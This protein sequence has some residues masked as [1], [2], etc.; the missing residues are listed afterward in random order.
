MNQRVL[1]AIAALVVVPMAS[2]AEPEGR[3]LE[4]YLKAIGQ[5][6]RLDENLLADIRGGTDWHSNDIY[7]TGQVGQNEASQLT[8]GSNFVNGGA[9]VNASGFPTVVQNSGNNVLIQNAT[10]INLQLQ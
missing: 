6:A 1:A 3:A 10:I 7:A 2:A 8:T 9:F 4:L 5:G